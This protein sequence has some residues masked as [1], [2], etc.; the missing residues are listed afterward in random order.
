MKKLVS[1]RPQIFVF[2]G[3]ISVVTLLIYLIFG[4]SANWVFTL[5]ALFISFLISW[6]LPKLL[7]FLLSK[8]LPKKVMT[9]ISWYYIIAAVL[10]FAAGIVYFIMRFP[11]T[12]GY[13]CFNSLGGLLAVLDYNEKAQMQ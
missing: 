8:I 6:G 12:Y 9:V 3:G 5:I 10:G 2:G 11:D 7:F 13:G 1:W 4:N